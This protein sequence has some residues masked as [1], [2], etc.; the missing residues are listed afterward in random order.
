MAVAARTAGVEH[1]A[2]GVAD[3]PVAGTHRGMAEPRMAHNLGLAARRESLDTAADTLK[4]HLADFVAR[5]V[6]LPIAG[7]GPPAWAPEPAQCTGAGCGVELNQARRKIGDSSCSSQRPLRSPRNKPCSG[8][9]EVPVWAQPAEQLFHRRHGPATLVAKKCR[10]VMSCPFAWL[11]DW[12]GRRSSLAPSLA[13]CL[14]LC[15]PFAKNPGSGGSVGP[16]TAADV[17]RV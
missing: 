14:A 1:T 12:S 16:T 3:Q 2:V 17:K 13:L 15:L 11:P 8:C 4:P 7:R 5:T 9:V 10:M 6:P